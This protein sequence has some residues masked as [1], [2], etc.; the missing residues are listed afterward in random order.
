MSFDR[1]FGAPHT[2]VN[3]CS[4]QIRKLAMRDGYQNCD[5]VDAREVQR[6]NDLRAAEAKAFELFSIVEER[7]LIRCGR[8]ER[9]IEKDILAI[10]QDD[11][12]VDQHWH[13]RIVRAGLNTL[14]V[15]ADN[16]PVLTV[17]RD[18]VVFLGLGPVFD[19][20]EADVGKTYVIG[21]NTSKIN[22]VKELS[23]QFDLVEDVLVNNPDIAGAELYKFACH[24]ASEAGYKFG[25]NI[26][27]HIVAEFPHARLPGERQN[28]HISLA[29]PSPLS[30]RDPNGDKRYWIIEIHLVS[31]DG[32]FG[33]FYERLA[34][35]ANSIL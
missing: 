4:Y 13:K 31:R 34:D 11:L 35:K 23:R 32:G 5:G 25:G 27:G 8:T 15:F 6:L 16:P 22:L 21:K 17:E 26:A 2:A 1:F 30:D 33:G 9:Q 3:R 7:E 29:N 10:A 24:S 14:S 12:G 19:S 20:W 18:D 28:H